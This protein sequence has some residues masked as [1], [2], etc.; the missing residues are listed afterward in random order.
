MSV[1][2][3]IAQGDCFQLWANYG[4]KILIFEKQGQ[5]QA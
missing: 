2:T 1:S 3:P 4:Q 5:S